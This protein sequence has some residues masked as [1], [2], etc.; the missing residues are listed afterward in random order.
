MPLV[1]GKRTLCG[2]VSENVNI[3]SLDFSISAVS[4]LLKCLPQLTRLL[5][6]K[7]QCSLGIEQG[8]NCG[9]VINDVVQEVGLPHR[10]LWGTEMQVSEMDVKVVVGGL[11]VEVCSNTV[12]L[13][14]IL[15]T[16]LPLKKQKSHSL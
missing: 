8:V 5:Q 11:I 9:D 15:T 6:H 4:F 12:F 3:H 16:D 7:A 2:H 1:R 13:H 14:S 10:G